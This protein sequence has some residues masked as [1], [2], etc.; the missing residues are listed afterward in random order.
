MTLHRLA[1]LPSAPHSAPPQPVPPGCPAPHCISPLPPIPLK[2]LQ[3]HHMPATAKHCRQCEC[4]PPPL[5]APTDPAAHLFS[6]CQQ[7]VQHH[8]AYAL[9]PPHSSPA[10][11]PKTPANP[12][13]QAAKQTLQVAPLRP[14]PPSCPAQRC[15]WWGSQRRLRCRRCG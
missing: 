9:P 1:C 15:C 2:A 3:T 6:P 5:P 13:R 4:P 14:L 8:N 11:P 7:V 12:Q 10:P